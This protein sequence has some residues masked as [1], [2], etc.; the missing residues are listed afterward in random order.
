MNDVRPVAWLDQERPNPSKA[1]GAALVAIAL[2]AGAF[3][4]RLVQRIMA[5]RF[6]AP[7]RIVEMA[8]C[9]VVQDATGQKVAWFYFPDDRAWS[10]IGPLCRS[11]SKPGVGP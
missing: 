6:P 8:G 11:R 2:G 9:S 4:S 10:R 7:W 5:G 3:F 1:L